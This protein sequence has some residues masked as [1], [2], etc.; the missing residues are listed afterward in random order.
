VRRPEKSKEGCGTAC[1]VIAKNQ[2][3]HVSNRHGKKVTYATAQKRTSQSIPAVVSVATCNMQSKSESRRYPPSSCHE[4]KTQG[5][6][7]S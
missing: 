2:K 7:P 3:Q 1:S 6:R 4:K 5:K